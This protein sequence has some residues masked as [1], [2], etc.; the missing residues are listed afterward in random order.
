LVKFDLYD[1][2]E[3]MNLATLL[4]EQQF[5]RQLNQQIRA[6][7]MTEKGIYSQIEALGSKRNLNFLRWA[8]MP[9]LHALSG[10]SQTS[11]TNA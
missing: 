9:Y 11:P 8:V 4:G 5:A 2:A 1:N 3:A 6:T 10:I 7:F